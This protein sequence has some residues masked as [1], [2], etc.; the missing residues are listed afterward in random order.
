[1]H[2]NPA[3]PWTIATLAQEAGV[4]R[5]V[6]AE[7]FRHYLRAHSSEYRSLNKH[8]FGRFGESSLG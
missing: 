7:R 1:M 2:R 3:H 4:S 5:S 6:L 8:R